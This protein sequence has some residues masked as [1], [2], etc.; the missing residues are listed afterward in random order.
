MEAEESDV[1]FFY[2]FTVSLQAAVTFYFAMEK[3]EVF[4]IAIVHSLRFECIILTDF[5]VIAILLFYR[6]E[7]R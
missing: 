1:R 4:C 7:Q 6:I 2:R 3:V 5:N